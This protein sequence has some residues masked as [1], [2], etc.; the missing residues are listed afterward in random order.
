MVEKE[1]GNKRTDRMQ[2]ESFR[3]VVDNGRIKLGRAGGEGENRVAI[4]AKGWVLT[5]S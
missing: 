2:D 5:S 4:W 1:R 3:E